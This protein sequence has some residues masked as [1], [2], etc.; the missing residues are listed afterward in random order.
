MSKN[1]QTFT[2][3]M[4][5]ILKSAAECGDDKLQEIVS[6]LDTADKLIVTFLI[7]ESEPPLDEQVVTKVTEILRDAEKLAEKCTR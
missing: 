3:K 1:L 2:S 6:L 5:A 7:D 4:D